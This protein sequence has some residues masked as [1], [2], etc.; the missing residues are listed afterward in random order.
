[1]RNDVNCSLVY[2]PA[3]TENGDN[4]GD[5]QAKQVCC[6]NMS[7]RTGKHSFAVIPSSSE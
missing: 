1:M 5:M 2:R 6:L 3:L 4:V 7:D